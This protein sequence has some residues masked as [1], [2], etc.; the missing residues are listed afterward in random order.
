MRV[1]RSS[2]LLAFALGITCVEAPAS[3]EILYAHPDAGAVGARYLWGNEV[4]PTSVPLQAAFAVAK[5]ARGSRPIEIRLLHSADASETVYSASLGTFG[6]ALRWHG[7]ASARLTI[8]GQV[9][10]AEG[11]PRA[12]T[13]FVGRALSQTVCELDGVNTCAP[14]PEKEVAFRAEAENQLLDQV[15]QELDRSP[16]AGNHGASGD[17]HFRLDC[18]LFWESAFVDV[19]D[20]GFRD[21]WFSAVASYASSNITLRNSVIDGST[22]AFLA[23]GRKAMPETAHSFE[24]TGNLWRQSP[25]AYRPNTAPC[26]IRSDWDCPVSIWSDLPWGIVHHHFWSPLNGALFMTR[27][28]LG[29]V[30]VSG[31][32]IF[33][34]YNGIRATLSSDCRKEPDCRRKAN[35]GFEI[36]GNLFEYVRDNPIEPENHA[37]FWIVK[38]NAFVNSYAAISTD[39]V[40]GNDLLVFANLFTLR[41]APGSR[42][43]NDGWVGSRKFLARRGTGG[44]STERAEA[45]DASC[46]THLMGTVVKLGGDD[47]DPSAPLLT[48]MPFFNNSLR[49]RSPL[50]RGFPGPA[51]ISHNN[52]VAFVGCGT[53]GADFCRQYP[54]TE[55]A[56]A[57]RDFWTKNRQA[58]VADCFSLQDAAGQALP[59]RMS[60]NAYS[61]ALGPKFASIDQQTLAA[62]TVSF[63]GLPP[64]GR[65]NDLSRLRN[66]FAIDARSPLLTGG[67]QVKYVA[68]DVIC[69][70]TGAQIGAVLPDGRLF[71]LELP[72]GFPFLEVL[73]RAARR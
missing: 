25:S 16:G 60:F 42:C 21:C 58:L 14:Q 49:T 55:S 73:R 40:S 29:N 64:L 36:T 54:I 44:W 69:T 12:L 9:D 2:V 51:I 66:T 8:R 4:V 52:A 3:A 53:E 20:A 62:E 59:H 10:R 17:I 31:N 67:C 70:G 41:E 13:V 23:V 15:T 38:H 37:A 11:M 28:A 45:D 61:H 71:D 50:F 1:A 19:A 56:C 39:G 22:W 18:L 27:D 30:L 35:N 34:A 46:D 6:S 32:H 24:V 57:G 47:R 33:D 5:A 43:S 7:S 68:G 65:V 63:A 72:F 48:S 26:Q